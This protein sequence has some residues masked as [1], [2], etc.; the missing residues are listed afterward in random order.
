MRGLGYD[1]RSAAT[2]AALLRDL[3]DTFGRVVGA[4]DIVSVTR[5]SKSKWANKGD[6]HWKLENPRYIMKPFEQKGNTTIINIER[7]SSIDQIPGR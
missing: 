6:A 1:S 4:V 7:A 2:H 5:N 3:A